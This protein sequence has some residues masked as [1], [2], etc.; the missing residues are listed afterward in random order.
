M[1]CTPKLLAGTPAVMKRDGGVW[2]VNIDFNAQTYF[3]ND[4]NGTLA[5]T[6][7]NGI[8]VHPSNFNIADGGSQGNGQDACLGGVFHETWH[9]ISTSVTKP[10]S[11]LNALISGHVGPISTKNHILFRNSHYKGWQY[12][13]PLID[14]LFQ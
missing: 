7:Y 10:I 8:D 11:S 4:I 9:Y 14:V 5:I 12:V 3:W 6:N 2:N 13:T 1:A